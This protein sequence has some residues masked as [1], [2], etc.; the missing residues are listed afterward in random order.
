MGFKHRT[1]AEVII[2]CLHVT[3]CHESY[4]KPGS[5]MACAL[6]VDSIGSEF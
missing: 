4:C 3:G 6:Q 5:S 1:E 2:L